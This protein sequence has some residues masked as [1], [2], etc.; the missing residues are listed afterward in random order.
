MFETYKDLWNSESKREN[1]RKY[2]VASENLRKLM[3]GDDSATKTGDHVDDVLLEKNN[4]R[5]RIRLGKV[6]EGHGPIAPYDLS[7]IEYEFRLP[8]ADEVMVAQTGQKVADYKLTDMNLEYKVIEGE[9]FAENARSEF[10]QGMNLWYD[11]ITHLTTE[12]WQKDSTFNSINISVPRASLK[13]VVLLF[14]KKGSTDSEEFCNAEVEKVKVMIEG[15]PNSVYSDGL[16]RS[17]VYEEAVRFFGKLKDTNNDNLKELDFLKDKYSLVVDMRTVD[18]ENVVHSGRYLKG[19]Q[20]GVLIKVE[21][22][23]T[24][25]N[26]FCHVFIVSDGRVEIADQMFRSVEF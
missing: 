16:G 1:M 18:E 3:S 26:L 15:N 13:A 25:T 7:T 22:L 17:Q 14:T 5:L 4:K 8:S 10:T 21:K 24:S 11:H 6:L 20:S 19:V 9:E 23:A 2:G 12:E